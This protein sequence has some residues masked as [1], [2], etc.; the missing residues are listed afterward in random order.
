MKVGKVSP[1]CQIGVELIK[2]VTKE[3]FNCEDFQSLYF[4]FEIFEK[5]QI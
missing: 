1:Y 4:P 5:R 3:N 2:I